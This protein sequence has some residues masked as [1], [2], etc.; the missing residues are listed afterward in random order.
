MKTN[1]GNLQAAV[2][3]KINEAARAGDG[4][5]LRMLSQIADEMD[6]KHDEWQKFLDNGTPGV[7]FAGSSLRETQSRL[8][9]IRI[10]SLKSAGYYRNAIQIGSRR[11]QRRYADAGRIFPK[12]RTK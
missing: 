8:A 11:K 3:T 1:L 9:A 12:T 6:R 2:W 7:R 10:C 4:G 5:S